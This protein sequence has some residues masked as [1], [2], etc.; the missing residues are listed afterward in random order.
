MR[1]LCV[2]IHDKRMKKKLGLHEKSK[3]IVCY[4]HILLSNEVCIKMLLIERVNILY[5][6]FN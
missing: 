3:G 2:I 6:S 1:E 5:V 4:I